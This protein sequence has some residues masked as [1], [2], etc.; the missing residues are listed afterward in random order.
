MA[1]LLSAVGGCSHDPAT[2]D[3]PYTVL[4]DQASQLRAD[5]N[6]HAGAIRL[7]FVVDP[8]CPGRL[9]GL[10]DMNRDL[11]SGTA[12]PR[13]QVFIVHEP[14][15]GVARHVPWLRIAG[16]RDVPKAAQLIQSPNVH[17]YWNPSGAFGRL[18]SK[19]VGLKNGD[20]QVY[21]W[22]LWLLYDPQAK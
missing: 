2:G 20:R 11:L 1:S 19:G 10:Q 9:R 3:V 18:L 21:A 15:L 16:G 12:D 17:H 8:I 14:V 4:D 5:F 6:Q 22:D 13:L 7:L